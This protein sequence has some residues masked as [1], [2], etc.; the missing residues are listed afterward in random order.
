LIAW[1]A[2]RFTRTERSKILPFISA[3]DIIGFWPTI[4]RTMLAVIVPISLHSNR[5]SSLA[6]SQLH[7]IAEKT[8]FYRTLQIGESTLTRWSAVYVSLIIVCGIFALL[9]IFNT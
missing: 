4:Q 2:W 5:I 3:G 8:S 1:L 9:W 7:I 6:A